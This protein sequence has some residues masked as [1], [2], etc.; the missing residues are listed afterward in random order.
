MK[1]LRIVE[2]GRTDLVDLPEARPGPG[3]VLVGIAAL[4]FCGS[5]LNSFRGRNP[6]VSYPRIPGHEVSAVVLEAGEG[7][8]DGLGAGTPVF[9][10]PYTSCG[11]CPSCRQ[12][13]FN[14]CRDNQTLGV[15]RDGA[16]RERMVLPAEK[17]LT[18]PGLS[19]RDMALVEPLTIGFHAADRGRVA[20]GDTVAVFGCGVVG[21]GA[22]S[23]AAR[24][25]GQVIAIDVDDRKL[26]LARRA[27]AAHGLNSSVAD[28]RAALE[29]LTKGDGPD[30]VIEAVG[31]KETYRAAVELVAFA[32]RVVYIGW[33]HEDV[34]YTTKPF[35]LKELDILGSRNA[36]PP[37]FLAVARMLAEGGF[38]KEALVSR[39]VSLAAAGLALAAWSADPLSV[40]KLQVDFGLESSIVR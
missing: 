35:V 12:R 6:L 4:G 29:E 8:A 22:I 11:R 2:P 16:A 33:A 10:V 7:V 34:A 37:D 24:R 25:G 28:P 39:A 5:D 26:A 23:A 27:G 38:P 1:A 13:R 9:V 30:V 20:A 40:T 17:L 19:L 36:T 21:L 15:Q 18:W 31:L 32:G 3:E 14:T